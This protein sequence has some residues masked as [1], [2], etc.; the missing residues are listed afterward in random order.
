M[1]SRVRPL[2]FLLL[3]IVGVKL[4]DEVYR[5][6]VFGEERAQ[7]RVLRD[8]LVEAGAAIVAT[9]V[10]SDS[11]REVM[12]RE[13][14]RLEEERRAL[15]RY[16][17]MATGGT[18][19]HD[20]Y[21]RYKRDLDRYNEHVT[22]R[23]ARL[24]VWQEVLARNHTAVDRYNLLADSVRALALRMG[25]LY[26]AVPTPL[27]AAQTKRDLEKPEAITSPPPR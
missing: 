11:M 4:S 20:V 13:D 12:R 15:R 16:D 22:A 17:R 24:R 5:W 23:N 19:P 8:D 10:Q 27:E 26:Y 7:V 25:E 18:L 2:L 21:L 9:R 3:V 6:A 14:D 1:I